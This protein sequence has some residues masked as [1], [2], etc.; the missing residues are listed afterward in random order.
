MNKIKMTQ[1]AEIIISW[2]KRNI[3]NKRRLVNIPV[4]R[5]TQEGSA[6]AVNWED[7]PE[8]RRFSIYNHGATGNTSDDMVLDK[9]TGLV[10][11]RD[12]NKI[13]LHNWLDSNTLCREFKFGNRAGW[14]LPSAEELSSL[15]DP[16]QD[17][18]ALPDGHPFVNVQSGQGVYAY[19]TST[20]NE[21]PG[22]SAWFV[23]MTGGD[24]G[25]GNKSISGYIWPV[26]GGSGGN[27]WNW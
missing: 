21:N 27:N 9:E 7:Y 18:P 22:S 14:R 12:A 13:G 6:K 3:K 8:N 26:R 15:V 17:D 19:W 11:T 10:W 1:S 16:S 2:M 20:N 24:A 5:I 23:N 25:L 4:W